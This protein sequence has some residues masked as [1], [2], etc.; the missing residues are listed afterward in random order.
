[1][2]W[3]TVRP[4]PVETPRLLMRPIVADDVTLYEHL[5]TDAETMRFIGAPLSRERAAKSFR[6]ALAG[7]Q[8]QPIEQLFL[9][10]IEKATRRGVG[11]CSLQ[12]FDAEGRSV[13][14]GVMFVA[15]ARA[16]GYGQEGFTG[17][18]QQVFAHW[19]VDEL[20]V[21]FAAEHAAVQ[22]AVL[23]VGFARRKDAAGGNGVQ[24]NGRYDTGT[25]PASAA[26][27]SNAWSVHRAWWLPPALRNSG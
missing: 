27:S 10:V 12:D 24:R 1:M 18:I 6:K 2:R 8:R 4:F 26:V 11:I 21:Q 19:P 7:M 17:L 20:W 16:Q 22:R 25:R 5:Y 15:S 13:Q 14:A 9:T 23:S 3:L